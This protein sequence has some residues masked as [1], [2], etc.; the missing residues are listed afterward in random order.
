MTALGTILAC[1]ALTAPAAVPSPSLAWSYPL[2]QPN[3]GVFQL[4]T[5]E[6][7]GCAFLYGTEPG[8]LEHTRVV[9]VDRE[10]RVT[11]NFLFEQGGA[12]IRGVNDRAL[13]FEELESY[14]TVADRNGN[15]STVPGLGTGTLP[16]ENRYT[17]GTGMCFIGIDKAGRAVSINRYR[18]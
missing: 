7:G 13:V 16:F 18:Y 9:W 17:D 1:M 14:V 2:A 5:D 3:N 15:V 12:A 4:L 6:A 10:G 11:L 8:S